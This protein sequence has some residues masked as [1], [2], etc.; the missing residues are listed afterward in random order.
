MKKKLIG[1][2]AAG[3]LL[4]S[5]TMAF[6]SDDVSEYVAK[7]FGWV[8]PASVISEK[9]GISEDEVLE[10]RNSG[11]TFGTIAQEQGIALEDFQ[12]AML[13]KKT[14]YIDER[15]AEGTMTEERAELLKERIEERVSNCDGTGQGAGACGLGPGMGMGYGKGNGQGFGRGA[16]NGMG[17]GRMAAN[18]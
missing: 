13:E 14:A 1:L 7:R 15:V 17:F 6:A 18:N 16:G 4:A 9:A 11:K 2:M 8:F 5:T 10:M 12:E 3:L